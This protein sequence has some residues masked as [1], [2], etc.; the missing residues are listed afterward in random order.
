MRAGLEDD[1]HRFLLRLTHTDDIVTGLETEAVRYP[2]STCP[3]AGPFLI[4]QTLGQSLQR[5]ASLDPHSHCTHL[6]ELLVLCAAHAGDSHPT[7]FDIRVPDRQHDRT[8]ATLSENGQEVL[9][10]EVDGT[11]I[12]GPGDWAGRDLRQLSRWKGSL[13]KLLAERATLLRRGL[14]ISNGRSSRALGINRAADLGAAR[15][16]AC[17]TYQMP[18]ALHALRSSDGGSRD[19]SR[20][21]TEPLHD[22]NP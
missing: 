15:M 11:L 13:P 9:R 20:L 19:F 3:A 6:F 2:W 16:G 4:E 12:A 10:W 8:W 21:G 5:L 18:R 22:F 14:H 1:F 17:F 7:R